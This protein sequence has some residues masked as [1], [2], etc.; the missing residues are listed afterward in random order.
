[1]S[2]NAQ[3]SRA[4]VLEAPRR[5]VVRELAVPEIGAD[6][7][8]VRV[9]A[10]GLCGTDHEQYTGALSG[11]FAFVPGHETV[12]II[13]AIG[14]Q[15][16]RRWGVAAGDRVAVEVFQSCRQCANCLAGEYR[17]CER[18]GLADMYGF[19]PVDRAPGLWGGYAEYQYLAP[20]S[21]VL[22]V[23]AGLDPA[24]ATLF[25][26]LGAGIRWG[27]TLPGTGA[28][29]VV[30]VLGPGVRGLC[31][32]AAAKE[33]GAGFVILTGVGPRDADRLALAGE[34]GVDLAVDVATDDPVAALA[35]ATGGL[36]DVVVDVT[37]KA[38]TAFAQAIAL[39]R[40]AG[41]VV[42]AGTR[43]MGAGAPGFSP[44]LVVFKELRILGALGV[45]ATAYRAALVMLASGRYPFE[46]LPRRCVRLDDAE[47]L[48]ATMAGERDGV[49][50]VHGVLTP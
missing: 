16:A 39:A 41:T 4:L 14:P 11:G 13:E 18:H 27:A 48:L 6:D 5:L 15:A 22:P 9:E 43:G 32:A 33:A 3:T 34:F 31:A 24:V 12:G 40:P 46:H 35:G 45:D 1:M 29:N 20:D 42:V 10:C 44:D 47:E 30:A 49:P 21:M 7:A 26:P 23:P 19:I 36:A 2:S 50:P 17:R 25:N 38:P 37:A 28:G 8:L